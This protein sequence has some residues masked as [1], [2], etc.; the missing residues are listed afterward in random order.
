MRLNKNGEETDGGDEDPARMVKDWVEA[1]VHCQ[2]GPHVFA[3]PLT[4]TMTHSSKVFQQRSEAWPCGHERRGHNPQ[5]HS[6]TPKARP[7]E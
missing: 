6:G 2:G 7:E 3:V 1:W 5:S 4:V